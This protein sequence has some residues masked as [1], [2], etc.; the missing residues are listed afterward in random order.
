MEK[1]RTLTEELVK[2][3]SKLDIVVKDADAIRVNANSK[4]DE[5][6]TC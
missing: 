5:S 4:Q 2:S 3:E 1:N 6:T